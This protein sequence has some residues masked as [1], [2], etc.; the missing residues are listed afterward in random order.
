MKILCFILICV[1]SSCN[2]RKQPEVVHRPSKVAEER[3]C[4]QYA[5]E[6]DIILIT[7]IKNNDSF[8]GT[9]SYNWF[10]KDD[11]FGNLKGHFRDSLLIA[12][13]FFR[14][15]G[16]FSVRQVVFKQKGASL[17]EGFGEVIQGRGKIM[18]KNVDLL[19]FSHSLVLHK[20]TC[21]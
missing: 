6:K 1:L 18:F 8:T 12:D 10:E 7:L 9:L 11:N 17:V 16:V 13:Y 15:E 3:V 2:D 14:S 20:I 19:D 4:Y 21:K 5:D